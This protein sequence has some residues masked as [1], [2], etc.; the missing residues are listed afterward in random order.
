MQCKAALW[1]TGA[2]RTSPSDGIEAIAG[3]IPV[4]LHIRKLNGRHHLRYGTI[5]SLHAINLLLDSQ[6]A[7]NHPP[8]RV[9]TS[10][11]TNK[12][13][14]NLKSPIK[15]VN[16]CLDSIRNCF[17]PTF[18]L[19]SPGSR[20]VD[21]FSSRIS[22]HSPS[23][24]SDED[25]FQHLQNLNHAFRSSQTSFFSTTIIT[26]G[27]IKKSHVATAVTYIWCHTP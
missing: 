19:F 10:K 5:S 3:L 14:A 24:S 18:P 12:Q 1:I 4:T 8:H 13:W 26:D 17:N 2:F 6:H 22:F 20:V 11:L 16:K 7:K 21:H 25:L 15:D 27:G 9:T 23:S